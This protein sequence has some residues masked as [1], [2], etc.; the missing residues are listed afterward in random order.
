MVRLKSG[1]RVPLSQPGYLR[2]RLLGFLPLMSHTWCPFAALEENRNPT[3]LSEAL[4][5]PHEALHV[6]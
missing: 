3:V 1:A 4:Q 6:P 2:P 5:E